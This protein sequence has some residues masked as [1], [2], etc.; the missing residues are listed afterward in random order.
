[1][2]EAGVEIVEYEVGDEAGVFNVILPIQQEEFQ[3]PI[4][5]ADQP[6]LR[7]VPSFYQAGR[8]G[9]WVA[10]AGG[11]V[12]GTLALKDIGGGRGALRKMF[13]AAPYRGRAFGTAQ[14]LLDRVFEHAVER[15]IGEI[16]LG[17]T[18][19]FL[20]AHSFYARNGFREIARSDL[21]P[22]FPLVAGDTRFYAIAVQDHSSSSQ[23]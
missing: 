12:V 6:D 16:F 4:T 23:A 14:R 5:A 7:D 17:T 21:P 13:V 19:Q 9:F 18:A 10:K 15:G 8:G 22:G 11:E 3:I 20:A 1:M 2:S